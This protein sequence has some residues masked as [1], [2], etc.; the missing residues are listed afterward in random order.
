MLA[1]GKHV[2]PLRYTVQQS[3]FYDLPGSQLRHEASSAHFELLQRMD[4][5]SIRL[6]NICYVNYGA[7]VSSKRPGAYVKADVVS[8]VPFGNSKRFFEGRDLDR[9][10]VGWGGLHLDYRPDTC[11]LY[12][13]RCV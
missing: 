9:Y 8:E 10:F 12:T 3:L 2:S 13:S 1:E 4:K 5:V 6:G 11:L 7:Q